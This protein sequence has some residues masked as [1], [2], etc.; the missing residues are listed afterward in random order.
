VVPYDLKNT[1]I[2]RVLG[3]PN[4]LQYDCIFLP[5]YAETVASIVG[6]TG[7]AEHQGRATPRHGC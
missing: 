6:A 5:E 2:G 4:G 7:G 3:R 1:N